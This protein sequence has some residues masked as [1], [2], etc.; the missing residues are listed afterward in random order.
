M[1]SDWMLCRDCGNF[2]V[3]CKFLA[4]DPQNPDSKE[5]RYQPRMWVP[6]RFVVAG[7][8]NRRAPVNGRR[9]QVKK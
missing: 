5:C 6:I 8:E 2:E 7:A 3:F 4:N 1:M 9:K